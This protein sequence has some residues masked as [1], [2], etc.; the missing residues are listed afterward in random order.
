MLDEQTKPLRRMLLGG[1][2]CMLVVLPS[3]ATAAKFAQMG[4]NAG[5]VHFH[6][7]ITAC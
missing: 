6:L 1:I 5:R 4:S 7:S 3:A 2:R